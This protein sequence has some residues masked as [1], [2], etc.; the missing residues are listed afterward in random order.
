LIEVLINDSLPQS[1]AGQHMGNQLEESL[2][3]RYMKERTP[4]RHYSMLEEL[5]SWQDLLLISFL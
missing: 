5:L 1:M 2:L 4:K 3:G